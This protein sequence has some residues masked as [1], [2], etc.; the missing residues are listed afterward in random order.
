MAAWMR[1]LTVGSA[2]LAI[3][4]GV[5]ACGGG[6]DADTAA[7]S[8]LTT[9]TSSALSGIWRGN[10]ESVGDNLDAVLNIVGENPF[11]ATIDIPGR[12]GAT[13]DQQS[14]DGETVTVTAKVTYGQCSD[15][16]WKVVLGAHSITATDTADPTTR[17][18]FTRN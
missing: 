15:S 10:W 9:P 8:E 1:R 6:D 13:W 5:A 17:A 14:R 3:T 12:C 18:H 7:S 11:V 16:E 2:A 4:V